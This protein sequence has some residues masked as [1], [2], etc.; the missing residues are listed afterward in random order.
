MGHFIFQRTPT[1]TPRS[2]RRSQERKARK[3]AR[4]QARLDVLETPKIETEASA[5]DAA[6][7]VTS[8]LLV[9]GEAS[10]PAHSPEATE[11]S[12]QDEPALASSA[13]AAPKAQTTRATG[14]KT[15]QGKA[16]SCLN[17]VK[18]GLTGRTVLLPS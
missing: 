15:P 13:A 11:S 2:I 5:E 9:S 3:L 17:A 12:E 1:L 16:K 14:P 6:E 7:P 10:S 8:K 4:K 18:T